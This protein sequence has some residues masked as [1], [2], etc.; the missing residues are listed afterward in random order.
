M[1]WTYKDTLFDLK[2]K[3]MLLTMETEQVFIFLWRRSDLNDGDGEAVG[4]CSKDG[5]GEGHIIFIQKLC[6]EK[7]TEE[8]LQ[9]NLNTI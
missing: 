5:W 8:I 7:I 6:E 9:H 1:L 3:Q 4:G 2:H